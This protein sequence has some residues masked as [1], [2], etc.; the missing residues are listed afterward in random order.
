MKGLALGLTLNQIPDSLG[1]RL[2]KHDYIYQTLHSIINN[3]SLQL[4]ATAMPQAT[5]CAA[6]TRGRCEICCFITN[7][8][9]PRNFTTSF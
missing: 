3:K 5:P 6:P 8:E 7:P 1:P 4:S 2:L 9:A